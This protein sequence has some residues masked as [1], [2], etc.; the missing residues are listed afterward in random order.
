MKRFDF[1]YNTL[2]RVKLNDRMFFPETLD[3]NSF[4]ENK[5][6]GD[7]QKVS[8]FI[9]CDDTLSSCYCDS[10]DPSYQI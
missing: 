7:M 4:I 6:D 5:I 3:L 8:A 1:D 10:F 9:L 2:H